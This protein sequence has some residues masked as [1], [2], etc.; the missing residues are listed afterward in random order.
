MGTRLVMEHGR[1][2]GFTWNYDRAEIIADGVIHAIGMCFG[3]VG[4]IVIVALVV[5]H[6]TQAV[7]ITA[8]LTYAVALAAMLWFSGTY[9]MWP[10]SP[11]K[12][13]LRRFDHSAIYLLIAG[14]YTPFMAQLKD[15]VVSGGLLAG[16]WTTAAV[17]IVLKLVLPGRF[18]RLSI[19][20]YLLL[21]W[22][23]VMAWSSIASL[24][25]LTLWLL[26]AGGALYSVGVVF[27]CWRSLRFQNAIWHAFVL[28]AAAC[29]YAAVLEYAALA[30]A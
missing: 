26:A 11:T 6:S 3:L 18:D 9:N 8:V 29:H 20:L 22:S 15:S 5:T 14:T 1:Q 24:P 21:G 17:G 2:V 27:H 13:I 12:W 28:S 30:H 16:V 19:A 23:G 25:A 4:G 7:V 10:V